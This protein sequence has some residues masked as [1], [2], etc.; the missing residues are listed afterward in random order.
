MNTDVLGKLI[1][2]WMYFN[3]A[4]YAASLTIGLWTAAAVVTFIIMA[5]RLE[6]KR[7]PVRAYLAGGLLAAL[8]APLIITYFI[9]KGLFIVGSGFPILYRS[10]FPKNELPRARV[11]R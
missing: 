6:N 8:F 10:F 5:N 11:I 1:R 9:G 7:L 3:G 4:P 2:D